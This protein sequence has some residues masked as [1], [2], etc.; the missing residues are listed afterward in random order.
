LLDWIA[1][2]MPVRQ[3]A[4]LRQYLEGFRRSDLREFSM[5]YTIK[6]QF[7]RMG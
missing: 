2:K 4:E 7:Y 6:L 1:S 5:P 3:P